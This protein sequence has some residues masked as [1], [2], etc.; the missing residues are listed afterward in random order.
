M[1]RYSDVP[2]EG[3]RGNFVSRSPDLVWPDL[4]DWMNDGEMAVVVFARTKKSAFIN[5]AS[6]WPGLD[7][8]N[9]NVTVRQLDL[10]GQSDHSGPTDMVLE[11]VKPSS[12][13]LPFLE[14]D[15]RTQG[16]VDDTREDGRPEPT[17][18]DVRSKSASSG[19]P[20]KSPADAPDEASA[21]A[22]Y[23]DQ[24]NHPSREEIDAKLQAIEARM[25]A[26]A[27]E[28]AG[29]IDSLIVRIDERDKLYQAQF[30]TMGE[31]LR[32]LRGLKSTFITTTIATGGV[33]VGLVFAA[34]ALAG[35]SFDSGRET[36]QLTAAA[37]K[38][39]SAAQQAATAANQ[40]AGMARAIVD[41]KSDSSSREHSDTPKSAPKA[42]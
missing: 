20:K 7:L 3:R 38:S 23:S 18:R 4:T 10:T 31:Q 29:K 39:S 16:H 32:D 15:P 30:A 25:D 28:T 26:R 27:A 17:E 5:A 34:M 24:M 1:S 40:A 41:P 37:E 36:A 42:E 33:V 22:N 19:S 9:G 35:A 8:S 12:A 21:R 13:T 6:N 14:H 11:R 2:A